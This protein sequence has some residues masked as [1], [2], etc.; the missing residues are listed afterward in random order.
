MIWINEW[1]FHKESIAE[2]A[3]LA[4]K[5]EIEEKVCGQKKKREF[6]VEKF[7]KKP[8]IWFVYVHKSGNKFYVIKIVLQNLEIW[9]T[10]LN[11]KCLS[12]HNFVV[13]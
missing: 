3:N 2:I 13:Q 11:Y 7:S 5:K 4:F 1:L 12:L 8:T 6:L 9:F 10:I